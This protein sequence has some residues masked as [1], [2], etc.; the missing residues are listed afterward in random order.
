MAVSD[1]KVPISKTA[2]LVTSSLIQNPKLRARY[3][4]PLSNAP[5]QSRVVFGPR[6]ETPT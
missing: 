1:D 3:V 2:L 4:F 6:S 5:N